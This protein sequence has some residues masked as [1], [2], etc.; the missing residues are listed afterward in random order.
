VDIAGKEVNMWS[1]GVLDIYSGNST[2]TVRGD[3]GVKLDGN[4]SAVSF[5]GSR[6]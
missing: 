2:V 6:V 1:K 3:R 5:L 4:N